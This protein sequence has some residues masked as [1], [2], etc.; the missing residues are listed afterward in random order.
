LPTPGS[1]PSL[2]CTQTCANIPSLL[3]RKCL[4]IAPVA[5]AC[6]QI[7]MTWRSWRCGSA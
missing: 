4:T 3:T 7:L 1:S 5:P 2:H 6:L